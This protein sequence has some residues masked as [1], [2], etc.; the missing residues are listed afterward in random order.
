MTGARALV[1]R[2][3]RHV[4]RLPSPCFRAVHISELPAAPQKHAIYL[5]GEREPWSVALLCPCG[6]GDLIHLSMLET[7][8]PHWRIRF[9]QRNHP[10]LLPS[11][12]RTVGCRSHF[13]LQSELVR[14]VADGSTDSIVRGACH[15]SDRRASR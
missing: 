7:D 12:W 1:L 3:W 4:A 6:C 15:E 14:W 11:V 2:L 8:S 13:I 10:T 5:I 9:D